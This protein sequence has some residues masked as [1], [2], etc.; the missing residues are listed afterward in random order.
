MSKPL[1]AIF[2]DGVRFD[3]LK[4][5]PFIRKLNSVPLYSL[6]GYSITCH[7]SMYTGLYPEKHKVAFHWVK[8]EQN[9]GPYKPLSYL[10]G[11]FPFSNPY[12]QAII[13]HF[14]AKFFLKRRAQPFMGYGKILNLPIKYWKHLD[15]NETKYW[16]EDGYINQEIKTIFELVRKNKL[17]YHVSRLHKPNLGM[18]DAVEVV[19]PD[20]YD[21]IYYFIGESDSV[22]HDYTQHSKEGI[23]LLERLDKFI[24]DRY[25]EFVDA[26]GKDGF[27]IVFWSDHGHIDIEKQINLYQ[28]FRERGEDLNEFFHLVDSTM[29]RFWIDNDS[30][31][32]KILK[33][34][35]DLSE[36]NFVEKKDYIDLR[37]AEDPNLYGN[38]FF[39]LDG[40]NV[41]TH[42]IHGFGLKTRSMHGYHPDTNE[43][44][45]VFSSNC[46]INVDQATLPDIFTTFIR[47]LDINYQPNIELDGRDI[48][49]R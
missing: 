2:A 17:N 14:Y 12:V 5:M 23:A 15:I 3:S 27:E 20:G 13:S 34:M 7:P 37:I 46:N 47:S 38:L 45:G 4:Y 40:G 25:N 22:S 35:N 43:N 41:F 8:S 1:L 33:V 24:E 6:L 39:Y 11:F 16:D 29:A 28:E 26:Y 36:C 44:L 9:Y 21:W 42:T 10:P 19:K 18:I 32:E 30:D 49:S 48:L 31:R